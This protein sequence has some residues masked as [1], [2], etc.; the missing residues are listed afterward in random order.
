MAR[1]QFA[2]MNWMAKQSSTALTDWQG[3]LPCDTFRLKNPQ[4]I[5]DQTVTFVFQYC[6]R[7]HHHHHY[8]H[9]Q[10]HQALPHLFDGLVEQN[11]A[12]K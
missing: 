11:R 5:R 1:S 12:T 7:Y 9:R 2:G 8:R 3:H 4:L 6:Y 10:L